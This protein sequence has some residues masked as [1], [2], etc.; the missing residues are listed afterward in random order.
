MIAILTYIIRFVFL[1]ILLVAFL[2]ALT[3][4]LWV[5]KVF[6]QWFVDIDYV[7]F[8]KTYIDKYL[9]KEV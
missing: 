2:I 8:C 3:G 4:S 7:E 9:N 5:L 1:L 6:V